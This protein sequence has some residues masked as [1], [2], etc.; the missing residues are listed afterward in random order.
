MKTKLSPKI[1]TKLRIAGSH[2][3]RD[4]GAGNSDPQDAHAHEAGDFIS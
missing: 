4:E 1:H 3:A 2:E